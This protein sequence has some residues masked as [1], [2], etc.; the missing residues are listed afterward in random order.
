MATLLSQYE[1]EVSLDQ[2]MPVTLRLTGGDLVAAR[3]F[4][5][6]AALSR[7]RGLAVV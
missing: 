5:V 6:A 2:D 3:R 7:L 4:E 1:S